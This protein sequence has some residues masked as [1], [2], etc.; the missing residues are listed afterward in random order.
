MCM[1]VGNIEGREL[2]CRGGNC[3]PGGMYSLLCAIMYSMFHYLPLYLP[4][5]L[6]CLLDVSDFRYQF[7]IS[8]FFLESLHEYETSI[9]QGTNKYKPN[10]SSVFCY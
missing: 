1:V 3:G 2:W 9:I 6:V 8:L 10:K 4:H 5:V 7:A